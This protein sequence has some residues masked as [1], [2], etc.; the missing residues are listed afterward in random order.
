MLSTP[1]GSAGSRS[2]VLMALT[3]EPSCALTSNAFGSGLAVRFSTISGC[4]FRIRSSP[5][6]LETNV[7]FSTR[8]SASSWRRTA[9]ICCCVAAASQVDSVQK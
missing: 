2:D 6:A 1:T 3:L 5:S 7:T 4:V 8:G 9:F